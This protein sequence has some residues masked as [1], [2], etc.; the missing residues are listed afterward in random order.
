MRTL[1]SLSIATLLCCVILLSACKSEKPNQGTIIYNVSYPEL[2]DNF[3]ISMMPSQMVFQF[4]D[5]V[6]HSRLAA[7]NDQL[8][9]TLMGNSNT[10][11][12]E[13]SFAFGRQ[14][15]KSTL[16]KEEVQEI[17]K[18]EN[19]KVLINPTNET[20]NI[21]GFNAKK[22]L[23]T[24]S[25]ISKQDLYYTD[26]IDFKDPNWSFPFNKL[27]GLPL[28]YEIDRMGLKM[29]LTAESFSSEPVDV[30]SFEIPSNFKAVDYS[31][32]ERQIQDLLESFVDL[33][34]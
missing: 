21:V 12:L 26:Q 25:K 10:Y 15:I 31:V 8:V 1:H 22:A 20:K 33:G 28:E 23:V 6:F 13:Q 14:L 27:E 3:L 9:I 19:G 7:K 29:K 5:N 30:S 4:K 2:E 24:S 18:K 17:H 34:Y 32:F 16:S 11:E